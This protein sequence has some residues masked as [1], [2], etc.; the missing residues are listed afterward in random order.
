MHLSKKYSIYMQTPCLT[1]KS[2][3]KYAKKN[4]QFL[5]RKIMY[6]IYFLNHL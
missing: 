2:N 6:H 5:S 1:F 3:G 4:I